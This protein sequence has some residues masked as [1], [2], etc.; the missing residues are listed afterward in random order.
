MWIYKY[1]PTHGKGRMK[2]FWPTESALDAIS[3]LFPSTSIIL[4]QYGH[5][6]SFLVVSTRVRAAG[7]MLLKYQVK[8]TLRSIPP[9]SQSMLTESHTYVYRYW[10][11]VFVCLSQMNYN[12]RFIYDYTYNSYICIFA[13][14]IRC[15]LL[16]YPTKIPTQHCAEAPM[17]ATPAA[18]P[19]TNSEPPVAAQ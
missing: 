13:Y 9:H 1:I 15:E 19:M 2:L 6:P 5:K 11:F 12:H 3:A 18:E 17:K 8:D 14:R 16:H 7:P 4:Y 10:I